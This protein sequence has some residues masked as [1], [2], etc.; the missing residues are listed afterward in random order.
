MDEEKLALFK[1]AATESGYSP[2]EVNSFVATA[3]TIAPQV[4]EQK[5]LQQSDA[6]PDQI[7]GK[8]ALTA[9][10]M[11][12]LSS[13]TQSAIIP[14]AAPV[15]Q[16]FGNRSSVEKYSKGINLGTDFAVPSQTPLA[17]PPGQWKVV[18]AR[19]G[20][21]DGSGNFVRIENTQTGETIGYEHLTQIGV[22]PGQIIPSGT[23]VGLSGG[24]QS[25]AGRGNST[26]AHASLPYTDSSGHYQ[27][28][29][30]SPYSRY[31]IGN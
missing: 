16:A 23:V 24:A 21:N 18:E 14:S 6:V 7:P 30:Q 13:G 4:E 15:T 22:Q 27:D 2:D 12:P 28:I 9:L 3:Q 1:Q 20:F 25:G 26:G 11:Q 8:Q 17:S 5:S 31:I 19:P 10:D 29:R